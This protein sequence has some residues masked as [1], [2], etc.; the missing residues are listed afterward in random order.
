MKKINKILMCML[1]ALTLVFV[2]C[3]NDDYDTNQLTGGV[4]LSAF[5]PSPVARG[6][7]L[8]F[9]GSNLDKITKV[10]IP[11]ADAITAITV[12]TSG[13]PSEIRVTVPQDAEV[14]YV[15]LTASNGTVITTSTQLTY[16][17]PISLES[18]SPA[19]VMPGDELTIEGDYLNLIHEVIFADEV[20]VSDTF[21][22]SHSRSKIVL[23]VPDAARTGQ[24]IIS[25]GEETPNYIYSAE[26]LIV[27]T[28]KVTSFTAD[29]FKAGETITIV[30]T[31]FD[32][33]EAVRFYNA[34]G[35][36]VDV[37][38][39]KMTDGTTITLTQPA[40]AAQAAVMLVQVSGVEVEAIAADDFAVVIP[41]DVAIAQETVKNGAEL[42]LAGED[43]DLV[44][45]IVFGGGDYAESATLGEDGSLTIAAVPTSAVDG[46]ITLNLASGAAVTV[47]Y[48]LV[49]PV[50]TAATEATAGSKVTLTG[51][52]LDLVTAVTVG[53]S[54]AEPLSA[55]AEELV[56]TL[57]LDSESSNIVFTLVNGES[58]DSGY[59]LTVA[60]AE[61]CYFLEAPE[62]I[63]STELAAFTVA[64]GDVLE[65]VYIND[66]EVKFVYLGTTVYVGIPDVSGS[67]S[68]TFNSGTK[69]TFSTYINILS[70][71]DVVTTIW[72]GATLVDWSGSLDNASGSMGDL[73][74]GGYDWSTV[75]AGMGLTIYFTLDASLGYWQVRF[76]NG[77]WS[78]LPGTDDVISLEEGMTSYTII[79]TQEMID[80]LVSNENSGLVMTGYG[81]ILSKITLTEYYS[82]ETSIITS[83]G[84][85][86]DGCEWTFPLALSWSNTG[87]FAIYKDDPADLTSLV[88]LGSI[89]RIYCYGTGQIQIN[90]ANWSSIETVSDWSDEGEHVF[91]VEITQAYID[92]L[93]GGDG[94]STAWLIIQGDGMT[95]TDIT[96]Q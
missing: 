47:S 64:N 49:K 18:F 54:S 85:H 4:S 94:W 30:G 78:A 25:D 91:E 31:R 26:E 83:S 14:G 39:F 27:G 84:T 44:T 17:E 16:T 6:G 82:A 66:A 72:D 5:G 9:I 70:K 93:N 45:S 74:W 68:I 88:S 57:P 3:N 61:Y 52:D 62:D 43:L 50:V 55:S 15:T 80:E 37:T 81:Y 32:L 86:G 29:R 23:T 1:S 51:T 42:V 35:T 95:I 60:T 63:Y 34:E 13:V 11:G 67:C 36:A 76:G 75:K 58:Y 21:F 46:D 90:D 7:E 19:E 33:V 69:G 79:L 59:S 41:T 77:S 73:S 2:A 65:A 12:K 22:T 10:E 87:R 24:I 8:R 28:S 38:D 56:F 40:E 92:A 20:A 71:L 53:G 96:I 48:T 89:M